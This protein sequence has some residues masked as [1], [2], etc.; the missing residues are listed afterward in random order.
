M[1][2]LWRLHEFDQKAAHVLGVNEDDQR[3]MRADARLAQNGGA[4]GDEGV[5]GFVDV[6]D[7]ETDV[8]LTALGVLG[9][10][11]MDRGLSRRRARSVRSGCWA[12]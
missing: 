8:V 6:L 1:R 3:T 12:G 5:A 10:E 7:L 11:A 2:V 9:Q 4:L